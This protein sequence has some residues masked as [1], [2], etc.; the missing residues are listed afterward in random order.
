MDISS[1]SL[2]FHRYLSSFSFT[3]RHCILQR[4]RKGKE[5]CQFITCKVNVQKRKIVKFEALTLLHIEHLFV[6]D[7]I[8][9]FGNQRLM[10]FSLFSFELSLLEVE[11]FR[12]YMK[13]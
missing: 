6:L 13:L 7:C 4:E 3:F 8:R 5:V 11:Y 10:V 9:E 1:T 12:M 2:Y